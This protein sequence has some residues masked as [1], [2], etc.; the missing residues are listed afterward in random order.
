MESL[1]ATDLFSG[2]RLILKYNPVAAVSADYDRVIVPIGFEI[3]PSRVIQRLSA[4]GF[5]R[6]RDPG[7]AFWIFPRTSY[8]CDGSDPPTNDWIN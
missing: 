5:G 8:P 6:G 7:G 2:L 3:Y 4:L 1:R